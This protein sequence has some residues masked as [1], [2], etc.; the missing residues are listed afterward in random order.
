MG[1]T[2]CSNIST[3]FFYC[4]RDADRSVSGRDLFRYSIYKV[5]NRTVGFS[6]GLH[7]C[8]RGNARRIKQVRL[9]DSRGGGGA[10]TSR[11][12][13]GRSGVIPTLTLLKQ[14]LVPLGLKYHAEYNEVVGFNHADYLLFDILE[15]N[16]GTFKYQY[17]IGGYS[18]E[19]YPIYFETT[20]V[21]GL[22]IRKDLNLVDLSK[23][24]KLRVSRLQF[25]PSLMPYGNV[26]DQD[27][28]DYLFYRTR[29]SIKRRH[30][31]RL[32]NY[33]ALQAL[34]S[35][36]RDLPVAKVSARHLRHY[37]MHE[38]RRLG[39]SY[40][41][42]KV[43]YLLPFLERCLTL[44]VKEAMF[45]SIL[46]WNMS[47]SVPERMLMATSDIWHVKYT[48]T[49]H[50]SEHIKK[51]FS[52]RLKAAQNLVSVDL[53]PF[54]ELEV[55]VNRGVGQV[56]WKAEVLN[57]TQPN[58]CNISP[59]HVYSHAMKLFSRAASL[60]AKPTATTFS[61][62]W[63]NRQQWAPTGAYHSQYSEDDEYKASSAS[64]KNKLYS[65]C[66]MP[67]YDASHFLNRTPATYAW[68]S[69]KYE[70]SKMRAIYGVDVTN[71]I[72]S[73]YAMLG[74][75]QV[76]DKIFPIGEAATKDNV[77][78]TV[79]EVLKNGVPYCMDFEDFNSQH[80]TDSMKAVLIAYLDTFKATFKEEQILAIDWLIKSL[81]ECYIKVE[82][83]WIRTQ[84]TL[85]SGWRLT[86]FMNTVLNH[87]YISE[88][89]DGAVM[90]STHN[91]DDVLAAVTTISQIQR[92]QRKATMLNIRF[93]KQK[94]FLASIAEFLRVDHLVGS[95]AQYLARGI[96][97]LVHGPTEALVPNDVTAVIRAISTRVREVIE[98]KADEKFINY[99][100]K[101]QIRFVAKLWGV[102][103]DTLKATINTHVSMGGNSTIINAD[104]L[105]HKVN[106]PILKRKTDPKLLMDKQKGLPGAH[107]YAR[108]LTRTLVDPKYYDKIV[109][110]AKKTIYSSAIDTRFGVS[111]EK[112]VP[113]QLD[114][115]RAE[116]YGSLRT[117][118]V[119]IKATM[120]KTFGLPMVA[121]NADHT[122]ISSR[123]ESEL[124]PLEAIRILL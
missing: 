44:D 84:G 13:C 43:P 25:G 85:L 64:L 65:L 55:L 118:T 60:R 115:V 38:V 104:T 75:E 52:L 50:F 54:F 9:V 24:A 18:V 45:V 16:C 99:V 27:V 17:L 62:Y 19:V 76:L 81:D 113:D 80:S 23:E 35:G 30:S 96:A 78:R 59:D 116:L 87:V 124:D 106:K 10:T 120:A 86:T 97:T 32:E 11:R 63:E 48:S 28:I 105:S 34:F 103:F 58:L 68:S 5:L 3:D 90:A 22:Y 123:L 40:I 20:G 39:F 42:Q 92:I 49:K 47:L 69:E 74:C 70:W 33:P 117:A 57:R 110:A 15:M 91:G 73:G 102:E 37:T 66:R 114:T 12:E 1:S 67:E 98:R 83:K 107:A 108:R 29:D 119:G 89:L 21:T 77:S 95:G 82:D 72:I 53:T 101:E 8:S 61:T 7:K 56:D 31:T 36:E 6:S 109:A 93:Q 46:L 94:C 111:V 41:A 51:N 71:F 88:C 26:N 122:Y 4:S 14:G 79:H 100:Y 2:T 121:I 112:R